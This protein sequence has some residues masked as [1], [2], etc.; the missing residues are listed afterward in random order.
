[1]PAAE[2]SSLLWQIAERFGFPAVVCACLGIFIWVMGQ[3]VVAELGRLTR[4]VTLVVLAMQFA[5]EFHQAAKTLH[6]ESLHA[7]RRRKEDVD[8]EERRNP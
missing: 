1:M 6:D 2:T 5:P 3:R 4:A 8:S 7:A